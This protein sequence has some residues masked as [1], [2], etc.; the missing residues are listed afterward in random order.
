MLLTVINLIANTNYS[1]EFNVVYLSIKALHPKSNLLG[2]NFF[3]KPLVDY[4]YNLT[5]KF[6]V[7]LEYMTII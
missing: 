7:M 1:Q 2:F 6:N 4:L 5:S 3:D